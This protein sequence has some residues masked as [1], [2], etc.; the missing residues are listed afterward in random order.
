M[1]TGK[2]YSTKYLLDSNNNRGAEGQ[3]L[4]TTSTGIDWVDANT[5]PGTGL[6]LENGNDIY[7]SNSADVGIGITNPSGKFH[8]YNTT[9]NNIYF[10]G[11][12]IGGTGYDINLYL[13][14]G[15]N[16]SEMS[17]NMGIVGN[18]DRD[19]IKTYQ[20]NM[21]FRT[22][23][24]ER[25]LIDSD[26]LVNFS[27][28]ATTATAVA[29]INHASNNFL[30]INGG[31]EGVA[32]GDDNQDTRMV[33]Y[34]NSY[35]RFDS[36]G[37]ERMRLTPDSDSTFLI[38]KAKPA[39]YNSKSFIT[40]YGTNSS[41]YGGSL[42]ARSS[43]SS[44]TDGGPY[45]SILKFT[46]NDTSNVEQT[47]ITVLSDGN[48]GIGETGPG[49]KLEVAGNLRIHNSTN[50]PYIDFVE[51]GAT[52]DSKARITMDQID[53]DNG[54]LL[55]ATEGTGTLSE[56]MRIDSSGR[57]G[58]GTGASIAVDAKLHIKQSASNSYSILRLEG[59]NRGG[60]IQM[61]QG[62]YPVSSI[63]TDQSGNTDINTSG[64]FGSIALSP[65]ITILTGG[66]VGIGDTGPFSKLQVGSNTFTGANG[67]HA[68]SRVGI[69]NHGSLTGMMLAS[70]YDDANH[71]EYGLV[72]VQGPS[73]SSY[74]VWSISPDGPLKGDSLSFIY[75]AQGTNIHG[76]IPKV[77]F[78]GNGYVGIG[79]TSKTWAPQS[80]LHINSTEVILGSV[81]TDYRDLAILVSTPEETAN[82][83]TGIAFDHG[84]LGA[85]ITSARV[86][87][88][89]WGT[90][91]R[92]YTH[93]D[94]TTNQR[95]VTERMR[96][97]QAGSVIIGAGPT[98]GTPTGDYRSLEIGRQGNTITGAPWK[99]N[100]YFSTNATITA[101]ST[102]F[103]ARYLNEL[104]MLYLMEDGI[105]QWSNAVLPTAVGDTVSFNERMRIN[106]AGDVGIFATNPGARLEVK[107]GTTYANN[108]DKGIKITNAGHRG[109]ELNTF[110]EGSYLTHYFE[111]YTGG[112]GRAYD[113]ALE[114]VCKGSPDGTYGE[115]VI[116]FKVNPINLNSDVTEVMRITGSRKVGIGTSN[117]GAT[118][119]VQNG[120]NYESI[121]IQN[122][123]A[124]NTNKQAGITSL[125]Y[126]GNSTSI[127]QYATNASANTIYYGSADGS[128]RGA[129]QHSFMISSGPDTVSHA[130]PLKITSALVT[131]AAD[132][133]MTGSVGIGETTLQ[134]KFNLY[135]GTD[136]WT[137]V[138]C[139]ASTADWL[140]GIAGSDHTYKWYNQS[141]N[142]GV[143]FK[144]GLATSGT[145]TVSADLVAY[146]SPSDKRL[147]EN[148]KPIESALDKVSKLQGV[149]FDWIQKEDQILDIK[150]D[151][152]FIAQDVQKVVPE[153]VRE[154]S[155]GIL[156]MRHQG[157]TPILLEAIKELK[158]EIEELKKQIK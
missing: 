33:C 102:T 19:R 37:V 47:R 31:T 119:D 117:P 39:T 153:L 90:D 95:N 94:S 54:T 66:N 23:D 8:V 72:F 123:Q 45:G 40:L 38:I 89:T 107:A 145:L 109:S 26:G 82:S 157:I 64:A 108:T 35:I 158:A 1:S 138:R 18:A 56:R 134:R 112:S 70:T 140:H 101:G 127:F 155:D 121:R 139:G 148:I 11:G 92:F 55:F 9:T 46:T 79:P 5:V 17:I 3:V 103:T 59:S 61:Y 144:M 43:I 57:V 49:E 24:S 147:K 87:N 135:D 150:E 141:S 68:N 25:M 97:D 105:F 88:S 152:G 91:L 69:S 6:W 77:V 2:T 63:T 29:S 125:N 48:V 154:N 115:G 41:T 136:T 86:T 106:A 151:I 74:N 15:A 71:P 58:I 104:P 118:L 110:G 156:S 34:N 133:T 78:D 142:G 30:Y 132:V 16:N 137:R 50:A 116:K 130:Q 21:Y 84:A 65:K 75:Q 111:N 98:S 52:T 22:N 27:K 32:I 124:V 76:Q 149:T 83:G 96:I 10:T 81:I 99:S 51:S 129:T 44:E 126:I 36:A 143:G 128:F 146:G 60:T 80:K 53:T 73:T 12:D 122:S 13:N 120:G 131:M 28:T 20:G 113:R 93:P 4:S 7:N 114:I 85:A 62:A 67:M 100:L 42:I 14:G